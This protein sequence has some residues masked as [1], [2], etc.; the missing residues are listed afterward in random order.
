MIL[1][2]VSRVLFG[3]SGRRFGKR[4]RDVKIRQFAG[5]AESRERP[6]SSPKD[7]QV[8][9]Y[10]SEAAYGILAD[11]HDGCGVAAGTRSGSLSAASEFLS[12][13]G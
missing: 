8:N 9:C 12:A 5:A 10:A 11:C 3:R 7:W 1:Y 6:V 13:G 2:P 4:R